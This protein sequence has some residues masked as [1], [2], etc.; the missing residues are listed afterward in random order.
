MA[1]RKAEREHL[2]SSDEAD[3]APLEALEDVAPTLPIN[4]FNLDGVQELNLPELIAHGLRPRLV[5]GA[6]GGASLGKVHGELRLAFW[7]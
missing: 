5:V 1:F 7:V 2:A 4:F 3:V 6:V